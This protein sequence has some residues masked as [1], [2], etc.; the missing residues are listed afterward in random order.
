MAALILNKTSVDLFN[1]PIKIQLAKSGTIAVTNK[2]VEPQLSE[3]GPDLAR[4]DLSLTPFR[5]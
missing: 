4:E 3:V 2:L 1:S 5:L